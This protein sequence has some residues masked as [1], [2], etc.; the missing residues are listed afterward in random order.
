M[1]G[2]KY[3]I[4]SIGQLTV[5]TYIIIALGIIIIKLGQLKYKA[6]KSIRPFQFELVKGYLF[7]KYDM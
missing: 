4:F 1:H 5:Y 7:G 2:R 6:E 3:I